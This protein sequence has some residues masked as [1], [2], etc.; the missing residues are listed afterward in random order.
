MGISFFSPLT[1]GTIAD[2]LFDIDITFRQILI[3]AIIASV[4]TT[5]LAVSKEAA[6]FGESR[7]KS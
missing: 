1:S 2:S 3:I 7:R 5:G 6:Q 4:F